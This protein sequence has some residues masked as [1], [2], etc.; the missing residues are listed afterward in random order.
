MVNVVALALVF[1]L[2]QFAPA[3]AQKS[4][5]NKKPAPTGTPVIW[6]E[7]TDLETRDLLAG[8]GGDEMKPDL[9]NVTFL[10]V[11]EGGY[12]PKFRVR[13]GA[14]REW[15]AKM[16]SEAQ[17]ETAAV[18]LVWAVGYFTEV[19][20]LVPCV[21]IQNAPKPRKEVARCENGGFANVRFEAR[22][23]NIDRLDE[24]KWKENPFVNT[25]ELQGLIILMALLNNWDI[26]DTNNKILYVQNEQG[27]N[28]LRYIISD[29][30]AT[31]GKTGNLPIFWRITRSRNKP[32]DF[33]KTRFIDEVKGDNVF[34]NYGG[35]AQDLFDDIRVDE[36]RWIGSLLG[37][38][39]DQQISDA[40][41][42]ANYT[43]EEIQILTEA[44]R[45]RID[46]LTAIGAS[47]VTSTGGR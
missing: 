1:T 18:R 31:F 34:F 39:S 24:W 20:Y 12:S 13:D 46:E 21:Q 29:L 22:P 27:E 30:G 11:E 38:L 43:P 25:K 14:G 44:V 41:R 5:K 32:E 8:P 26:K 2:S 15:V 7:P 36:A 10:K 23:K 16:G 6:Q 3:Y 9:T 33:A 37:R 17:S 42:A 28:Q 19:N 4:K 45:S 40:F 47:G 35:K